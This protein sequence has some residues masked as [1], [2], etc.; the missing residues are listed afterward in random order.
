[1]HKIAIATDSNSGITQREAKELGIAVLPMPFY[2]DG[3]LYYEDISLTQADFFA[4]LERDAEI[5]TSQPAPGDLLAMWDELLQDHDEVIFLPMSS[6]LSSGCQTA[7][8]LAEDYGGRVHVVDNRRISVTLREAALDAQRMAVAGMNGSQIRQEL[9]QRALEAS[10]YITVDTLKYLKKGGRVTPAAAAL[11]TVLHFKPVLQIQ[12]GKLDAFEKVRGM[13][14]AKQVMLQALQ[15]DLNE[16][17]AAEYA[18]GEMQLY[19]A[20][21]GTDDTTALQLKQQ[22]QELYPDDE[23]YLA[24]LSLSICCHT[25]SG[26]I[27][28]GCGRVFKFA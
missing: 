25:G 27:G 4:H 13:K 23:I 2:I 9:E 17:F 6:G 19:I 20:Y 11:G 26:A 16:R 12:G 15:N 21:S 3:T 5:T 18:A 22:L 1:M 7:Q 8:M 24:P 10:I 28:V 14:A